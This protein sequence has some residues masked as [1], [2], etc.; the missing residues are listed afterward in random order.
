MRNPQH[1]ATL[2]DLQS[3]QEPSSAFL[4]QCHRNAL[5]RLGRSFSDRRS[6]AILAGD[7]ELTSRFVI[8]KFLSRLDEEVA[9]ARITEP[10][11]DAIEFMRQII[12]AVGFKPKDMQLD[13]LD[14]IFSMFLSFQKS[15]GRRT[16]I[17]VEH[18]QDNDWWVLDKIREI[19]EMERES[20]FGLLMVL[21]GHADL[22]QLLSSRPLSAISAYATSRISLAPL[23]LSETREYIGQKVEST[24]IPSIDDAFEYHAVSLIHELCGG[25]PEAI[26]ELVDRC[27]RLA[28]EERMDLVSKDL[29][30]SAYESLREASEQDDA[31]HDSATANVR[32][33]LPRVGKLVVQISG[34]EVKELTI[35][36]GHLLVGRSKL[37]DIRL[38]SQ[39]ISRHHALISHT[40]D[41]AT[42]I[43]L[44]STN[45][46]LVDGCVVKEHA[47]TPGE[48]I[49]VGDCSIEYVLEDDQ[50]P[51]F[52]G[53]ERAS[54]DFELN[55]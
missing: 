30:K 32:S 24:G 6:L 33:I 25:I 16:V 5:D 54:D 10:C 20:E 28:E 11:K 44:G 13:D 53:A 50:P 4:T 43:D 23:T 1:T 41:G 29:V 12:A 21:S 34:D 49:S 35:R 51:R 31:E 26:I 40:D 3:E 47:L 37:C 42:I 22:N 36:K 9:V 48:T 8:R 18:I 19:V 39:I 7:S 38:E 52:R 2:P 17:C 27:F 15:H 46:T 14:S 45:G 55:A